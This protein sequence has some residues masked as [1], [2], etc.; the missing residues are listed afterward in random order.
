MNSVERSQLI[1]VLR[2]RR[3]AIA[4]NWCKAIAQ[5]SFVSLETTET[6]HRLVE[7][8]RQ[9]ITALLAEPFEHAQAQA[10]GVSLAGLHY[11]EPAALGQT[12]E[13][14]AQQLVEGLPAGQVVALQPRLAALLGGLATG[15]SEQVH[16]IILNEQE[17]ARD[18]LTIALQQAEEALQR[19]NDELE[20][21]VQERTTELRA[22]NESLQREITERKR[23]E[24]EL[25]RFFNFSFDM[26]CI[27]GFDGYAKRVNQ[28]FEKTLGYT[29][30]EI[31]AKPFLDFVHPEDRAA[32]VA[33]LER[34]AAGIPTVYFEQRCRCKDGSYKWLAWTNVPAVEE[35]L[36][37]AVARNTT[38]R[39]RTEEAI[40]R[41]NRELA[42]LHA[43]ANTTSR[44]L[45]LEEVLD[46]SLETVKDI[47]EADMGCVLLAEGSSRTLR[48]RSGQGLSPQLVQRLEAITLDERYWPKGAPLDIANLWRLSDSVKDIAMNAGVTPCILLPLRWERTA[49]GIVLLADGEGNALVQWSMEFLMTVSDQLGMAVRNA[50]LYEEAQ[51]ELSERKRA[52]KAL[53]E[54][55]ERYRSLFEGVPVG[56]F[57]ITPDGHFH[58]ANAAL[59]KMLD[60]P[61]KESLLAVPSADLQLHATPEDRQKRQAMLQR[62]VT[63]RDLEVQLRRRDGGVIWARSNF[64][65]AHDADGQVLHYEGSVEDITER[66]R[67]EEA[68]RRRA[69]EL[70]AL[71]ATVLEIVAPHDLP[72]LLQTVVERAALLLNALGGGLYLCDSVRR[73]A[74][75]VVSYNTPHDYTGTM[76]KY[77]EG[78]AGT[79]AQTGKPLIIDD[80]RTWS[81]RATVYEEEQPFTSVLSAPMIWQGRVTGVIHVLH[82]VESRRFTEAD[83]DL[84]TLFANHAAIATENVRLYEEAQK[85]I[86]ERKRAEEALRKA[87]AELEV[88]VQ[89]RTADLVKANE[90]LRAE[91]SERERAEE[92]LRQS[93]ERYRSLFDR[94]PVGLY[95]TTSGGQVVD[96]NPALV[97]MLG[98]P[99]LESLLVVNATDLYVDPEDR[100]RQQALLERE[101][102]VRDFEVKLR[103]HD[104][105]PIWVRD[106]IRVMRD[107]N[108]QV[109]YYEGGLEDITERK[110]VEEDIEQRN[111]EL[112]ALLM[113]SQRMATHLDPDELLG[114]IAS[115]IVETLPAADASSLWLYDEGR[116]E[117]VIHAW[118]GLDDEALSGL[119][120][121]PD[122]GLVGLVYRSHQPRIVDDVASE[123]A[124]KDFDRPALGPPRSVLGVP[125]LVEGRPI[126]AM[127]AD[128]F[129][130]PR[131]FGENDMHLLQSL[132]GQAA[133]AIQNAQL[134]ERVR[135]GRERLQALSRRLVEVQEA[136]RR[137]IALE[138]HDE[139]GQLLTGL[140]LGLE[141]GTRLPADAVR[142]RLG[143][144][145][146]LVSE[147][148][149]RVRDL[150][151]DLRPAMLDDLGLLP[152]L[153]WHFERYAAQT[154]VRVTFEHH[155]LEGRFAPEVETAAYRIVQEA[156]TNV[157]RHAG[158]SEVMVRLWANQDTLGV[159][160]ED[161][162]TGFDP[163][164]ALAS[165]ATNGLA[166]MR[167]RP[168]LLGG[169]LTVESAP[170]AGTRVTAELPL[171]DW[172]ERRSYDRFHSVGR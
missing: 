103:C 158:V 87:H 10:I 96:V 138:L 108:G 11:I 56:L 163:E 72:T 26:L 141:V 146:A 110:R 23:A 169:Q 115:F 112:V 35:G 171:R 122:T 170:G 74:R 3:D 118:A 148:M 55:E 100:M 136:E 99:D 102:V 76:L 124:F 127:F 71:Q 129:S 119:T 113:A 81:R 32:T 152:A 5:I 95:R 151:L 116:N 61:D 31:L 132:A 149:A 139:I 91:I 13:V 144:A 143:E 41:R 120:L 42:A 12:Q 27:S 59:L 125:L 84:L 140:K 85:E 14:L 52:G 43:I 159:Q 29:A 134:F 62:D 63:L 24:E 40:K 97:Q 19:A 49:L 9:V 70:A 109:L 34:L 147:L 45:H 121:P 111:R 1:Q 104:G 7:L 142:A 82:D 165:G 51:R 54:S 33:Q 160:I 83:L 167:E 36:M 114:D 150:S 20:Q 8:T 128:N 16:E 6:R 80:Y 58:D 69:E 145:Q 161:Q 18:A 48:V 30:E 156:L 68:L 57:R 22:I 77:S 155:G 28:A 162:G 98:Y 90:A 106:T 105:A 164:A 154:N 137:H 123:P 53:R 37:Y 75:C 47:V 86:S 65:A 46:V 157:A 25:D 131:A 66:K 117:L 135:T 92:A 93:E 133:V 73:E 79:V 60:Y 88:R 15:F 168:V 101:G 67:A 39:K 89:E 64:R 4:D 21:R 78:A 50:Q 126:G 2:G 38:E 44:H 17:R 153:L 107:A 94:V 166:G 172:L 130:R